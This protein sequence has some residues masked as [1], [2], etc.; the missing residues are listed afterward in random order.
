[1]WERV[2]DHRSAKNI[3]EK[4]LVLLYKL[5]LQSQHNTFQD[6]TAYSKN[7]SFIIFYNLYQVICITEVNLCINVYLL[8]GIKEVGY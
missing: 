2:I 4:E 8:E 7:P 5:A 3:E 6:I 1:M